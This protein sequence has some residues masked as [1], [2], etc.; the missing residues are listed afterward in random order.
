MVSKVERDIINLL[1]SVVIKEIVKVKDEGGED[2]ES[3]KLLFDV[4]LNICLFDG[5]NF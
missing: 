4:Y 1:K 2:G 3:W 5:V